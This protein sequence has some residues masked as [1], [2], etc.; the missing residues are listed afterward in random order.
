[1]TGG[2]D[3]SAELRAA[4][5]VREADMPS[6]DSPKARALMERIVRTDPG[7]PRPVPARR[8]TRR[9]AL[10]VLVP[11]AILAAGAA[12][13]SIY[14]S[15]GDP[16]VIACHATMALQGSSAVAVGP[17]DPVGA[18]TS[19]WRPGGDLNPRGELSLPLL[20][21]CVSNGVD[22]VFPH[23]EGVDA[24]DALGLKHAA[25]PTSQEADEATA[26]HRAQDKLT[27]E[28]L[29]ACETKDRAIAFTRHVLRTEGLTDWSVTTIGRPF[30]ESAPCASATVKVP[31]R[32]VVIASVSRTTP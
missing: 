10:L 30:T 14:R 31:Q 23:P 32:T 26:A 3:P 15:A 24:C 1:M 16:L 18:C 28:L 25:A 11:V 13:F 6:P 7:G 27:G 19:M 9:R 29:G 17:G 5:P 22:H 8:S 2:R 4:N 12:G 20:E 21:A